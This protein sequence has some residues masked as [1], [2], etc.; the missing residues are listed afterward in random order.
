MPKINNKGF[1]FIEIFLVVA[2]LAVIFVVV[3][4]LL[5]PTENRQ[6]ANDTK[7]L[8]DLSKITEAVD[9][10]KLKY[11]VYPGTVNVLYTSNTGSSLNLTDPVNGWIG[12]DLSAFLQIQPIDPINKGENLYKYKTD[13]NDF[14]LNAVFNYYKD[15]MLTD[16]GNNN[17]VF[18]LGTNLDLIN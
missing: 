12:A 8:L 13:G 10:Y 5:K 4:I 3:L 18:E 14:E 11:G 2:I 15:K 17:S 16:S 6:K 7:R 9:E 1:T